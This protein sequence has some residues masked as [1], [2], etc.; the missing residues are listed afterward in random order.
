[1]RDT[2][3]D[4]AQQGNTRSATLAPPQLTHE[5][6]TC[7]AIALFTYIAEFVAADVRKIRVGRRLRRASQGLIVTKRAIL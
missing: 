5:L 6:T 2:R 3:H 7:A 1:L 4:A